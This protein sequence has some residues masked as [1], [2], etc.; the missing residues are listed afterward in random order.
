MIKE[1]LFNQSPV[2]Y[3]VS[4][5]GETIMLLHGFGEDS[6]IFHHQQAELE[7]NYT[8]ILVDLPGSGRS[9]ALPSSDVSIETFAEVVHDIVQAEGLPTFVLVGHSMG[10]YITMAYAEKYAD[11]LKAFGWMHSTAMPDSDEKIVTRKKGIEFI[12]HNGAYAFLKTSIPNLFSDYS[13]RNCP[14]LISNLIEEGSRFTN[15][16]LIQYYRAMM[17]R[18]DRKHVLKQA[19]VPVLMIAGT[20]DVAAPLADVSAQASLP[21]ECHF[22]VLENTGHMGMIERPDDVSRLLNKFLSAVG[23][24]YL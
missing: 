21:K 10:G 12:Q 3:S 14:E 1:I 15:E 16:A 8:V 6:S 19:K 13:K 24:N 4:G 7:K 9:P 22:H 5:S 17:A 23:G 20:E 11:T 18:P 2:R